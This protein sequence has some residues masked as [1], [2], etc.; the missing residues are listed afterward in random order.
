MQ[1]FVSCGLHNSVAFEEQNMSQLQRIDKIKKN[2]SKFW[3]KRS[4]SKT[5]HWSFVGSWSMETKEKLI[6]EVIDYL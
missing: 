5:N 2:T 6:L 4:R 3:K 1:T